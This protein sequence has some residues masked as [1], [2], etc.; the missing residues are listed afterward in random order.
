MNYNELVKNYEEKRHFF[1]SELSK[2]Y[3]NDLGTIIELMRASNHIRE[4]QRLLMMMNPDESVGDDEE[5]IYW[6]ENDSLLTLIFNMSAA[7]TRE[8]LKLFGCLMRSKLYKNWKSRLIGKKD[9]EFLELIDV[10]ENF[11]KQG[12]FLQ[13]TLKPLRDSVYHYDPEKAQEWICE[14]K[15]NEKERKPSYQT[16]DLKHF[17]FG[18]G[19]ELDKKLFSEY[20][21]FGKGF[22]SKENKLFKSQKKLIRLQS[23]L[24]E[25]T[26]SITEFLLKES[27]IG[28]RKIRWNL[29]YWHGFK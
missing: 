11:K 1:I 21:L 18:P 22:I 25:I 8:A 15:E 16:V 29:K 14:L 9:K 17:E 24:I 23:S 27:N 28:K 10:V 20:L 2:K 26:S 5:A 12:N 4:F 3:S 19:S 13:H 6:I 7:Q